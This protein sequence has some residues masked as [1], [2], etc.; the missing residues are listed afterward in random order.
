MCSLLVLWGN[1]VNRFVRRMALDGR[2]QRPSIDERRLALTLDLN[3]Q[4]DLGFDCGLSSAKFV[5]TEDERLCLAG[6][7]IPG[8]RET[9][10]G[11]LRCMECEAIQGWN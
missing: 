6:R 10:A 11:G 3:F 5:T 9:L 8:D 7:R 4:G 1:E 2:G